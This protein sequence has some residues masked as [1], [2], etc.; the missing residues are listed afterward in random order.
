MVAS[1]YEEEPHGNDDKDPRHLTPIKD[2]IKISFGVPT[3]KL[4]VPT[5]QHLNNFIYH[6]HD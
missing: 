2:N 5:S 1:C 4:Q 3:K 6:T